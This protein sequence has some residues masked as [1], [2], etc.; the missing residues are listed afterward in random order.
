MTFIGSVSPIV[1]QGANPVFIDC[2]RERRNIAPAFLEEEFGR[3]EKKGKLPKA[4]VP[5]DMYGQCC[6]LPQTLKMC[7]NYGIPVVC[8][9]AEAL[10]AHYNALSEPREVSRLRT[11]A[12][13]RRKRFQE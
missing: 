8:D 7:I 6:P 3:C 5:T 12:E 9:S 4:V 13:V 11:E 10:G 1:F 2:D